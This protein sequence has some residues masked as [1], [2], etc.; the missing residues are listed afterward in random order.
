MTEIN[1]YTTTEPAPYRSGGANLERHL[2][3]CRAGVVVLTVMAALGALVSG[4]TAATN[5]Y[6]IFRQP[7]SEFVDNPL[8][9]SMA[10]TQ[11]FDDR[12]YLP[13]A[14][15]SFI[16]ASLLATFA[17]LLWSYSSRLL[18]ASRGDIGIEETLPA[19]ASCW[20]MAAI[21]ALAMVVRAIF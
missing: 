21:L 8:L 18:R 3:R 12:T 6:E 16:T 2:G 15:G 19:Q 17:C 14:I 4:T 1:P 7:R 10:E 13:R 9:Q 11:Q 5:C 20:L